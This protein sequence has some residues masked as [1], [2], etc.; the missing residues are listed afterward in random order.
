MSRKKCYTDDYTTTM[1]YSSVKKLLKNKSVMITM[2]V[3]P[4]MLRLLDEAMKKDKN[5]DSRNEFF[6]DCILK[7]LE[8]KGKI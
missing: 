3:N 7:Y 5:F 4:E 8:G 2:R 6:E 1:E